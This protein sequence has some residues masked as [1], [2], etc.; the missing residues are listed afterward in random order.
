MNTPA[1][2]PIQIED[3]IYKIN[4]NLDKEKKNIILTCS[5]NSTLL[6]FYY[7]SSYAL[8]DILKLNKNLKVFED[9]DEINCFIE[10]ENQEKKIIIKKDG[11]KLKLIFS[12]FN[13]K[14][15]FEEK[16]ELILE[17]KNKNSEEIINQL[18]YHEII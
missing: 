7:E 12:I 18:V 11:E 10:K 5:I 8:D 1:P 6:L 13:V 9:I 15:G 17:K 14:N 2:E 4:T 3:V 16:F